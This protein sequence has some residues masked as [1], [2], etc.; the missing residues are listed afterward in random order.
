MAGCPR[1]PKSHDQLSCL[2]LLCSF[3]ASLKG[4]LGHL[5]AMGSKFLR[6]SHCSRIQALPDRLP[7][8]WTPGHPT[9]LYLLKGETFK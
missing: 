1:K 7:V 2:G 5:R 6:T 4:V 8:E 9:P 3:H